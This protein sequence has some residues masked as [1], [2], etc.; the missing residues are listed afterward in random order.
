MGLGP[1]PETI[2]AAACCRW[3]LS[4]ESADAVRR[5]TSLE[6]CWDRFLHVLHRH[7]VEGLAWAGLRHAGV[8]LPHAVRSALA[9]RAADISVTN[10]RQA[11][12]QVRL[13][14]ALGSAKVDHLFVKGTPLALLAYET[15]SLKSAWDIDLLVGRASVDRASELLASLGYERLIPDPGLSPAAYRRWFSRSKEMLWINP[16]LGSALELHMGLVDNPHL[17]SGVGMASPRQLVRHGESLSLPTLATEELFAYLCVH[18]TLHSW[19]R[20]KWL[21]DVAAL[22]ATQRL[23]PEWLHRTS[24]DLGA[25]Y[26]GALALQLCHRLFGTPLPRKLIAEFASDARIARLERSTFAAMAR[27]EAHADGAE[28]AWEMLRLMADPF[29]LKASWRYVAAEIRYRL[30]FPYS[31]THLAIW[32]CFWPLLTMAQFPSFVRKRKALRRA[33]AMTARPGLVSPA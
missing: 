6:I 4:D 27:C 14:E 21:A 1:S 2:L 18:G 22:V 5:A 16:T 30:F 10:L 23:D 24:L 13:H 15:L 11:V 19:T 3:P 25:G 20:L 26:C 8:D 33:E 17:L 12:E 9:D 28:S 7:R 32:P 29:A 31:P